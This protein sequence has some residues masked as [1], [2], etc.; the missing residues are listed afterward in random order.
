MPKILHEIKGGAEMQ[1]KIWRG[2]GT[3]FFRGETAYD[4]EYILLLKWQNIKPHFADKLQVLTN[5]AAGSLCNRKIMYVLTGD[6]ES[7]WT[8]G[9]ITEN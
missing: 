3:R 2:T 1:S 4:G 6:P 8:Q 7:P 9:P 5:S